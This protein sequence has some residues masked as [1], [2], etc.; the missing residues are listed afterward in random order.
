MR[1]TPQRRALFRHL[2]FQKWSERE[3][4][5]LTFHLQIWSRQNGLH[6]FDV[7]ISKRGLTIVCFVNFNFQIFFVPQRRALFRHLNYQ[8]WCEHEVFLFVLFRN[9]LRATTAC[10]FST[11]QLPKVVQIWHLFY[12]LISKYISLHNGVHFFDMATSKSGPKLVRFVFSDFEMC[13]ASQGNILIRY[14]NFQK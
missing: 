12:I 4:V 8:K 1:F 14:R 5:F 10:I 7:A 11:S 9:V 13:F 3:V 6:F 2:N